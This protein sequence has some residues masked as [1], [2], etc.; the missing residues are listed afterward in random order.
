M[1]KTLYITAVLICCV[2]AL[3]GCHKDSVVDG[4]LLTAETFT[5]DGT[6]TSVNGNQVH[7]VDGDEIRINGKTATVDVD[8]S[9]ARATGISE[10][11][12]ESDI[13]G[14]YPAAIITATGASGEN[15]DSPTIIFP[16]RY[17][18]S[19]SDGRQ[20]IGLPMVGCADANSNTIFMKHVSAA[21]NVR[22]KNSTGREKLYVDSVIVS[23]ADKQ[24][25]GAASVTL[26]SDA[27]PVVAGSDNVAANRSV[28]VYFDDPVLISGDYLEV[29]VPILP[30]ASGGITFKVYTH[31][32]ASDIYP[33]VSKAHHSYD[34][35]RELTN[36]ALGRNVLGIAQISV[37]AASTYVNETDR[38]LFTINASGN[39][40]RFAQGNLQ[41]QASTGTWRFADNQYD[42]IGN[43][44]GNTTASASRATQEDWIDLFGWGTSGWNNN[45]TYYSP[46][47]VSYITSSKGYGYGPTNG[48]AYTYSLT[49]SYAN[50][51]WGVYCSI[52]NGGNA[53]NLWRTLTNGS[54]SELYYIL[55]TRSNVTSGLPYGTN[56]TSAKIVKAKVNNKFGIIIFPDGYI[57]P[58]KATVSGTSFY[59]NTVSPTYNFS[60]FTVSASS[61]KLM[62]AAGAVFL[63]AAGYRTNVSVYDAGSAVYYWSSTNNTYSSAYAL[64]FLDG[65]YSAYSAGITR[66]WGCAVRLV[67]NM[68]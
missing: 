33:G 34:Y 9:M 53:P 54:G 57:H 37:T 38:G 45:N 7:W 10:S 44:A 22:V 32:L 25:C 68:Y 21:I 61:W 2:L 23:S 26:A 31:V 39:K 52:S 17:S 41:Y 47:D 67:K 6:K 15:T 63:P 4:I 1:K 55:S 40:V 59:Y 66:Y 14:Y 60:N 19:F 8:G 65:E 62:E 29:Q 20:V 64:K 50:S 49:G 3:A 36:G 28:T 58:S 5:T 56:S 51:D 48:T 30:V 16:R 24:L 46:S 13:R 35:S 18:S 12:L 27:D 43:A 42:Y 11:D